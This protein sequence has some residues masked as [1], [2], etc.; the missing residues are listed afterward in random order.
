MA[1][2]MMTSTGAT[3]NTR[4]VGDELPPELPVDDLRGELW[5]WWSMITTGSTSEIED[6]TA[7]LQSL[8]V[9][10]EDLPTFIENASPEQLAQLAAY[11]DAVTSVDN[12]DELEDWEKD[13]ALLEAGLSDIYGTAGQE[14]GETEEPIFEEEPIKYTLPPMPEEEETTEDPGGGGGEETGG[15]S[16]EPSEP[17]QPAEPSEPTEPP[18]SSPPPEQDGSVFD[19]EHPWEYIGNGRFRHRVT[20]EIIVDPNYDPNNDPFVIGENYSYGGVDLGDVQ[21]DEEPTF[22]EVDII[23]DDTTADDTTEEAEEVPTKYTLPD[24]PVD[25]SVDEADGT[26]DGIEDGTAEGNADDGSAEDGVGNSYGLED[27]IKDFE[28]GDGD[29]GFGYE[30]GDGTGDGTG[31]GDGNGDGMMNTGRTQPQKFDPFQASISYTAPTIQS[32][33]QSPQVD[34]VAALNNIINRGMLT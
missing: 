6:S 30:G 16:G 4:P 34:Y 18:E 8:G 12:W 26:E 24:S 25:E 31:D 33:V 7:F 2:G 17:S 22:E 20:G 14:P 23:T 28:I 11:R 13:R 5:S 19:P 10:L 9:T 29:L 1:D 27:L 21:E 32:L 15:D 3:A